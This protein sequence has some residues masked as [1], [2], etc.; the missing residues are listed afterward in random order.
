M[1][2]TDNSKSTAFITWC[3]ECKNEIKITVKHQRT[4]PPEH[5]PFCGGDL[6]VDSIHNFHRAKA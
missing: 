4:P 2:A 1:S 5:C 6:L 3:R